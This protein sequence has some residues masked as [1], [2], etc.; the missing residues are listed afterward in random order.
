MDLHLQPKGN[1][2]IRFDNITIIISEWQEHRTSMDREEIFM[3]ANQEDKKESFSPS[4]I[5]MLHSEML[6]LFLPYLTD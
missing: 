6:S 1:R 4:A 5:F 2:H 3:A